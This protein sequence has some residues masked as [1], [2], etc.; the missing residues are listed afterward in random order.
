M[1]SIQQTFF[2]LLCTA[3]VKHCL[4]SFS[5]LA[6]LFGLESHLLD[7]FCCITKP[8]LEY[9]LGSRVWAWRPVPPWPWWRPQPSLWAS[10]PPSEYLEA[11]S[12][13]WRALILRVAFPEILITEN[14]Q[15]L[16]IYWYGFPEALLLA[17]NNTQVVSANRDQHVLRTCF[18]NV[19]IKKNIMYVFWLRKRQALGTM[20]RYKKNK[21]LCDVL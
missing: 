19:W 20:L 2:L 14:T 13:G 17:L 11:G 15:T 6:M 3:K 7:K 1:L 9:K 18:K 4:K 8:V 12:A 5:L 16:K 21:T 10:F